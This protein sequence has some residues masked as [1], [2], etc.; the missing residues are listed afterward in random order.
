MKFI[1]TKD[2]F[3]VFFQIKKKKKNCL[4]K[5]QLSRVFLNLKKKLYESKKFI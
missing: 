3:H 5:R 1:F 2:N 4:Y